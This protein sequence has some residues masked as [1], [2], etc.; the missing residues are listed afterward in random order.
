MNITPVET[1]ILFEFADYVTKDGTFRE[2]SQGGLIIAQ[3]KLSAT[4]E[5]SKYA[6]VVNVVSVGPNCTVVK[7]GMTVIVDT[8]KWTPQFEVNGKSMWK[9][10]EEHIIGI[11]E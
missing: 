11:V 10:T 9:T 3:T 1:D 6:R 8:L 4:Q 2:T 5:S 7:P